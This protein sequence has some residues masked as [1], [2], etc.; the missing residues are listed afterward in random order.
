MQLGDSNQ[1]DRNVTIIAIRGG[2]ELQVAEGCNNKPCK[3][4][5]SIR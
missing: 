3:K 1:R 2:E 4:T 5:N